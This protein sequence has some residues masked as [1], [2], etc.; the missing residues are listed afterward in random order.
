MEPGGVRSKN[1]GIQLVML[2]YPP[3]NQQQKHMKIED[4]KTILKECRCCIGRRWIYWC[5]F[6]TSMGRELDIQKPCI[7]KT[8]IHP[9]EANNDTRLLME[10]ILHHLECVKPCKWRDKLSTS[11]CR[12]SSI[13][14]RP[15]KLVDVSIWHGPGYHEQR[16]DQQQPYY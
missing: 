11:W 16:H 6:R 8:E 15:P 3:W 1:W 5:N 9:L 13:N 12:I 2:I 14:N 4:W 10:E 7:P